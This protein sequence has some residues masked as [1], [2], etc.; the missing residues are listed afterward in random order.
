MYFNYLVEIH[1]S[2]ICVVI[3]SLGGDLKPSP[4]IRDGFPCIYMN[5]WSWNALSREGNPSLTPQILVYVDFDTLPM[6]KSL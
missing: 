4:P 6:L 3:T 5:F 1:H 2:N